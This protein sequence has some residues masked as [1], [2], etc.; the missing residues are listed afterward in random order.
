MR[1]SSK[2]MYKGLWLER[3]LEVPGKVAVLTGKNGCGKT[4]FLEGVSGSFEVTADGVV[5]ERNKILYVPQGDMQGRFG[6]GFSGAEH[7]QRI[8]N[9]IRWYDFNKG[10]LAEPFNPVGD[11]VHPMDLPYGPEQLYKSLNAV[12]D[13]LKKNV[14]E[15]SGEEI[16]LNFVEPSAFAGHL[17]IASICNEYM[18]RERQN[19]YHMW[20]NKECGKNVL[21]VEPGDFQER[22]G[23]PPWKLFNGIIRELFD[24]KLYMSEPVVDDVYSDYQ[25]ELFEVDTKER[26]E[27]DSLSS[28]ERNLLWMAISVFK[29]QNKLG[30]L[31][32]AP[33]LILMDEPDALLHPK[34][35]LKLYSVVRM[36]AEHFDC[37][38]VFSTHSPTTVALASE[39][40]VFRM[41]K[42][43]IVAIDRD[44]A[45]A[46]LLE[47]VS[48][49][50]LSPNN[51]REV[52]VESLSDANVYRYIFDKI[53]SRFK[54]VDPKVSLSF[55]VAGPK[56]KSGQVADKLR[57]HFGDISNELIESFSDS[58]NGVGNSGQV[59]A[60]V[61]SLVG[62]GNRSVKGVIDWDVKNVP[63][64]GVSVLGYKLFYTL[65][66]ILL[67][68]IYVVRL[69]YRLQPRLYDLER[70][71]GISLSVE[72]WM[73]NQEL[74][75]KTVDSFIAEVLGEGTAGCTEIQFLSGESL[76]VRSD[77]LLHQGHKL[78]DAVVE[79]YPELKSCGRGE[80]GLLMELTRVMVDDFGWRFV[81]QTFDGL[82]GELQ[83]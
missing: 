73:G 60:M 74:L 4:R 77:Y 75:Q 49:I 76:S 5:V 13:R 37:V 48:Q 82:F 1:F 15:L 11:R 38:V 24:G 27:L 23:L 39:G 43:K 16:R 34:M 70:F 72:D 52:F 2:Q 67:N 31:I 79:K 25:P 32:G 65:E 26:L 21:W 53:K 19:L 28:G 35:V 30:P 56:M 50:S 20:L 63:S 8:K 41:E 69:L 44:S 10:F 40:E 17:S 47:G 46:D 36:I 14:L 68:P 7:E 18:V 59:E 54:R 3:D 62:M 71:C 45:I 61:H 29:L 80:G 58:L 78:Q 33:K 12:A 64:N 81:P 83:S 57:Q 22:F 6:G 55:L 42:N 9:L 51:R 66:N